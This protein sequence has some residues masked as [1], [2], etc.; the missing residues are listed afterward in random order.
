MKKTINYKLTPAEKQLLKSKKVSLKMLQDYAPDEIASLLTA[1]PQRSQELHALAEFQSIASL[2]INFAE[3][4]ISQ[5]Y[6]SL[7]E[8]KGKT[9]VELFDAFERHCGTWADP[10]VEDSYRL[11]V[12]YNEN[13]DESKRWWHFTAE[14]KAY[15]AQHGFPADRPQKPWYND[16]KYPKMAAYQRD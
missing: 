4:L 3:E 6:Y 8:F 7:V 14:R 12:H 16:G 5:G 1:S 13:R 10:C 2:G 9:A 11:L 15:R